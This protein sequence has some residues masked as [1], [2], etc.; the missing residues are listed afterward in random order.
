ME[1]DTPMTEADRDRR[2]FEVETELKRRELTIAEKRLKADNLRNILIGALV[3][4]VVALMT[5]LP[6]YLNAANQQAL[7]RAS[8]EAQL[9]TDPVRT[10]DPDQAAVNLGFLVQSGLLTGETGERVARYL[11]ER[12]PGTGRV[13]PPR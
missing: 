3:P 4:I 8:F 1:S 6:A 10:G 12:R 5:G 7:Q 11:A 2:R 13:L 9:F